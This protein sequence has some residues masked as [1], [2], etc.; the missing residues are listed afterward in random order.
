MFDH[1]GPLA[2]TATAGA[3]GAQPGVRVC[4]CVWGCRYRACYVMD[5]SPDEDAILDSA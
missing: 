2:Q 4:V 3:G 5:D 1:D